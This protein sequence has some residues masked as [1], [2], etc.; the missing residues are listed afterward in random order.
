[1]PRVWLFDLD[2][3]LHH[4]SAHIFPHI[5]RAMTQY[6]MDF[7]QVDEHE[8][9][10]LR[11]H[12]W[13]RYGATLHGLM[14][15]HGVDAEHFLWHTHQ[16]PELHRQLVFDRALAH[17]LR[18][19]PGK[20]ILFSNGP[21]HYVDAVLKLMGIRRYFSG[22]FSIEDTGLHPKPSPIGY[23]RLLKTYRLS[24]AECTLVEDS[25]EN[26]KTAKRL[27]MNTIWISRKSNKPG[28]VDRKISSVL[29]I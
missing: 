9:D 8:A 20:K 26:L 23:R 13:R 11:V 4:A 7:L 17:K 28:W 10:R 16:F 27:G 24:P 19:L 3:T 15:H 22:I 29:E 18:Q 25:S 14:R 12:Y 5:N 6:V 21:L 2:D 1:M